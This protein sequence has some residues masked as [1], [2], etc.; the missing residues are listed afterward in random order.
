MTRH[1][2]PIS[3][4]DSLATAIIQMRRQPDLPYE[5][6]FNPTGME[7]PEIDNWLSQVEQ[8]LDIKI[9]RV[10]DDLGEIIREQRILPAHKTRYCT[11][12]AKIFPMQDWIGRELANVYYGIRADERRVGYQSVAGGNI[13]PVYPLIEEGL[14]LADVW[15]LVTEIDLLPP[16]FFWK[17]MYDMVIQR[18]GSFSDVLSLFEAW[19]RNMLFA[20]RSRPNCHM[21]FYQRLYE[22]V[23]LL[24]HHP[25]LFWQDV[26]LEEEIGAAGFS[27]KQNWPLRKI[28]EHADAIKRK[29]CIAICKAIV[30]RFQMSL[31]FDDIDMDEELDMLEIVPCGLFCGK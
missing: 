19:E 11:R 9:E 1:I 16:Q 22:L 3:G 29:R 20:W 23:G 5:F 7:L 30:K 6:L 12:F 10:G 31:D 21:C 18:L 14:A 24:E 4:K 8:Y 2:V 15:R 27:L 28:A 17:S 26:E 25:D 13:T